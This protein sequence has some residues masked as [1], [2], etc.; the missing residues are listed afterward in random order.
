MMPTKPKPKKSGPVARAVKAIR[1]PLHL[2]IVGVGLP[3]VNI[4]GANGEIVFSSER[5]SDNAGAERAAQRC[6]DETGWE[7][8]R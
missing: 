1:R 6:A 5:Y 7:I 2:R 4:E 3:H 8:K